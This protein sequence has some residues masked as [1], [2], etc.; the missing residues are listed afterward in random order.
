MPNINISRTI[1]EICKKYN[2][3]YDSCNPKFE[4]FESDA[5]ILADIYIELKEIMA[6][7]KDIEERH[8]LGLHSIFESILSVLDN[9]DHSVIKLARK[10]KNKDVAK[11]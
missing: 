6:K 4:Y 1:V 10:L 7:L 2:I 8:E 9:A 3:P 5:K 11:E